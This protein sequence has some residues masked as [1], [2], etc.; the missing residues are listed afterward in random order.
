ML[1]VK[2]YFFSLFYFYFGRSGAF[3]CNLWSC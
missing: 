3:L 2:L 1:K